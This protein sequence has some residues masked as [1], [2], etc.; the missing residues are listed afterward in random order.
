MSP[1]EKD[2]MSSPDI[3]APFQRVHGANK[4][5]CVCVCVCVSVC[6]CVRQACVSRAKTTVLRHSYPSKPFPINPCYFPKPD[7][8]HPEFKVCVYVHVRL[9]VCV[10]VCVFLCGGGW[11]GFWVFFFV[12]TRVLVCS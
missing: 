4:P 1:H 11:G 2:W 10:C 5:E 8:K 6:V 9:C 7:E 12:L 3:F